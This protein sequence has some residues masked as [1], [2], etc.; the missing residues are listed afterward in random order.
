MEGV[1]CV[2]SV[3]TLRCNV[4]LRLLPHLATDCRRKEGEAAAPGRS[5]ALSSAPLLST[6]C[7]LYLAQHPALSPL[8]LALRVTDIRTHLCLCF[9]IAAVLLIVVYCEGLHDTW[10]VYP[11]K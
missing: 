4:S 6:H 3:L 10:Q 2:V 9:T 7:C 11:H 1:W 5:W 8:P